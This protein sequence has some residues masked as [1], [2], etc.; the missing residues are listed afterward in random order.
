MRKSLRLLLQVA[1]FGVIALFIPA[2]S[3]AS[4]DQCQ[5][6]DP[7]DK[8]HTAQAG[9]CVYMTT[10]GPIKDY[11]PYLF[12]GACVDPHNPVANLIACDANGGLQFP[13][14]KDSCTENFG[15]GF[16]SIQDSIHSCKFNAGAAYLCCAKDRQDQPVAPPSPCI[17]GPDGYCHQISTGLGTIQVDPGNIVGDIFG[18]FL[19]LA[20]GIAVVL[21][22][23]SGY[24]IIFA[25][26][27]PEKLK[28]AR[29]RLTSAIIGLLFIIFSV[30]LVRIIGVDILHIPGLN[31]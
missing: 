23:I 28:A 21:I 1:I 15:A 12:Y 31:K 16:H 6:F 30:V 19:G 7:S 8:T 24:Q 18:I 25:Q 4:V 13:T 5:G 29:E 27:D 20:G 26:A 14:G 3:F 9:Q 22:I 10:N 2:V 11:T 17:T